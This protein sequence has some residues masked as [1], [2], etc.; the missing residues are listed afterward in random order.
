[1]LETSF[2]HIGHDDG[3]QFLETS[4]V[5][6]NH[7]SDKLASFLDISSAIVSSSFSLCFL[8]IV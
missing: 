4:T 3:G 2:I 1:L 5:T 6:F 7:F 8:S